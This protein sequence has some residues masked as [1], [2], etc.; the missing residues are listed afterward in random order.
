LAAEK[1]PA[2]LVAEEQLRA[3][4]WS[5]RKRPGTGGVWFWGVLAAVVAGL[6]FIIARLLPKSD[7]S[8]SA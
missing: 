1:F 4:P 5:E 3:A 8:P 2:V 7:S 6:L